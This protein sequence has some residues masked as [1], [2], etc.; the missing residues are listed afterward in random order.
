MASRRNFP[1]T[2]RTTRSR[3]SARFRETPEGREILAILIEVLEAGYVHVDVG[4]PD[5]MY[6]WPY[7]ARY[8]VNALTPRQIVEL[9]KLVYL[10]RLRGHEGLRRLHLLPRRHLA[11]R[12]L[13]IL[14][15]RR[16]IAFAWA[17]A[18]PDLP[19]ANPVYRLR[20]SRT[21]GA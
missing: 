6:V 18:C 20:M 10:R 16:L 1:S 13:A 14:P 11:G 15:G 9:F 4:T 19:P 5:E 12:D 17:D 7:F 2:R 21:D 8:P 3:R